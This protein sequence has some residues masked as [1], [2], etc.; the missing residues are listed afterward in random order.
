MLHQL[1]ETL[2]VYLARNRHLEQAFWTHP[3]WTQIVELLSSKLV[4]DV[5]QDRGIWENCPL[6]TLAHH[7]THCSVSEV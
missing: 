7:P 5:S 6:S 1:A 4:L 3:L 2:E